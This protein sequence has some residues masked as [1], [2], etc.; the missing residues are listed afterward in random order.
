MVS[1]KQ[2]LPLP[3]FVVLAVVSYLAADIADQEPIVVWADASADQAAP[4]AAPTTAATVAP[5]K[6]A[7]AGQTAK[8]PAETK[9][10]ATGAQQT[11]KAPDAT[12][13]ATAGQGAKAPS[14]TA[15]PTTNA[16]AATS[17]QAGK[18][19]SAAAQQAAKAPA[20]APKAG[21]TAKP[22]AAKPSAAATKQPPAAVP[23]QQ[24]AKTRSRAIPA[25]TPEQLVAQ[26]KAN[27]GR[28]DPFVSLEP[29]AVGAV[30]EPTGTVSVP[31]V[32]NVPAVPGSLP[33]ARTTPPPTAT[34]GDGMVV[35]GIISSPKESVAI[36]AAAGRSR[37]VQVGDIL[38]G[39]IRIVSIE[40]KNKAVIV[41]QGGRSARLAVKE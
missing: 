30:T 9:P 20:A 19:P 35:T 5:A 27:A 6:A 36:V 7:A 23:A 33:A 31:N 1:P 17:Q 40:A 8:A 39:G 16:P 4:A 41:S 29:P 3:I 15:Q 26:A 18:A 24:V 28:I 12:K 37:L 38:P 32:P 21:A 13:P 34:P 11:A 2:W 14:A 25:S 22:A 10:A